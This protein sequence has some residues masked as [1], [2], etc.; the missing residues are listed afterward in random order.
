MAHL[1]EKLL[2]RWSAKKFLI[3]GAMIAA[4]GYLPLQ[5]YIMFGPSNGNPIGLGLLFITVTPVGLGVI[6]IGLVKLV[7]GLFLNRRR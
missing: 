6:A 2:T 5:L 7:V 1:G 3:A 4:M